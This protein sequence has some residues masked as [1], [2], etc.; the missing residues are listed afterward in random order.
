[1]EE[2][3]KYANEKAIEAKLAIAQ[4][5]WEKEQF[6]EKTIKLNKEIEEISG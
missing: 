3:L 4:V 1:M 5:A 6:Q 2:D